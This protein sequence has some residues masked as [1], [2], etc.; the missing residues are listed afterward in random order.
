MKPINCQKGILVRNG[1]TYVTKAASL[2]ITVWPSLEGLVDGTLEKRSGVGMNQGLTIAH[3]LWQSG[4]VQKPLG[5]WV[6][7][8]GLSHRRD[9]HRTRTRILQGVVPLSFG[10]NLHPMVL[11]GPH[12]GLNP[13]RSN[14][15]EWRGKIRNLRALRYGM[16]L[17]TALFA[18]TA[19]GCSSR[20]VS[21]FFWEYTQNFV[22][23]NLP[24]E[25]ESCNAIFSRAGINIMNV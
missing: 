18:N 13:T 17:T 9:H 22:S 23:M 1:G 4:P 25:M 7:R 11:L 15:T 10:G 3:L 16:L 14:T 2:T 5:G 21:R 19:L 6:V 24:D 12:R 20:P 8:F